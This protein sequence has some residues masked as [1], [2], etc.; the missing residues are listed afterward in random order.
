MNALVS[1]H[2][3]LLSI[4]HRS[5]LSVRRNVQTGSKE[6]PVS[7]SAVTE[8]RSGYEVDHLLTS[9]AEVKNEWRYTSTLSKFSWLCQE[10]LHQYLISSLEIGFEQDKTYLLAAF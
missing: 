5:I 10:Q 4:N 8:G 9:N 1:Q 2:N 7:Y 3:I 6:L